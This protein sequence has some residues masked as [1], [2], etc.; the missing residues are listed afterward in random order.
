MSDPRAQPIP[1]IDRL[2]RTAARFD[3][4]SL[5]G[6]LLGAGTL[7][8]ARGWSARPAQAATESALNDCVTA[9][10][11]LVTLL[12]VARTRASDLSLDEQTIRLMRAAQCQDEAHANNLVSFGAAPTTGRFSIP[13]DLF[14]SSANLLSGWTSLKRLTVSM[15]LS[16]A[17]TFGENGDN[18]LVELAF[19]IGTVE[20]QHLALLRQFAGER[21]PADRAFP[22]WQ[23]ADT[24]EA[25]AEL[26]RLGFIGGRGETVDYPGPGERYCRG[27]T[28]LVAETTA[29][30]TPPDVTPDP[31]APGP[32]SSDATPVDASPAAGDQG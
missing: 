14:A 17:R 6:L 16:A 9:E 24:A 32:V 4:R 13:D 7:V 2:A 3:R 12:G 30:Q 23:F 28:G 26:E 22:E 1:V 18:D 8:A 29:D 15:Y 31:D 10:G 19:Q 27:I 21:I 25:I 5:G 11:L 20:A